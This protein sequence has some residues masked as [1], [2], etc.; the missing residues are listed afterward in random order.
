[1]DSQR[2]QPGGPVQSFPGGLTDLALT[3]TPHC[4]CQLLI[5]EHDRK[6]DFCH[7]VYIHCSFCMATSLIMIHKLFVFKSM[8]N[9][10]LSEKPFPRTQLKMHHLSSFTLSIIFFSLNL[11]PYDNF[12]F[13]SLEW[14]Y[15]EKNIFF[16]LIH[17]QNLQKYFT[18]N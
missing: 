7:K 2:Q 16:L 4:T 9:M 3:F 10:I 1:M 15:H 18:Y 8:F 12:S 14:E 13:L 6:H 11:S 17:F 5:F